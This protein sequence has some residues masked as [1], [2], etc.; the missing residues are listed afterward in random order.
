MLQKEKT[1]ILIWKINH[2]GLCVI[3][4]LNFSLHWQFSLERINGN[5][6]FNLYTQPYRVLGEKTCTSFQ[7]EYM[8]CPHGATCVWVEERKRK[9]G[10]RAGRIFLGD[11]RKMQSARASINGV[12]YKHWFVVGPCASL[13]IS[14]CLFLH[15]LLH[16][17]SIRFPFWCGSRDGA[18]LT[19]GLILVS[20]N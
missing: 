20:V 17:V 8:F 15:L 3:A 14:P 16:F 2:L 4:L 11:F 10:N 18:E 7:N 13:L 5:S 19:L 6:Q 1:F 12:P 9:M